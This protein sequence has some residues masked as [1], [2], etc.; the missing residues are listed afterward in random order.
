MAGPDAEQAIEEL[1]RTHGLGLVRFALLLV[2]DQPTAEDVV[3]EAFI[4]LYRG[5]HRVQDPGN[6]LAY[7]RSSVLN[8]C[9]SALRN[10]GRRL[11]LQ[12]RAALHDPPVWSAA[13]VVV[14]IGA[15]IAVPRLVTQPPGAAPAPTTSTS[16]GTTS[17]PFFVVNRID[18]LEVR[19]ATTGRIL[20]TVNP[21]DKQDGEALSP[22]GRTMYILNTT[23]DSHD[24]WLGL[25][26]YA[27]ST[28]TGERLRTLHIWK[29][30]D[31]V[32]PFLTT[33]GDKALVWDPPQGPIREVDL[34][35]GATRPFTQLPI[36]GNDS[37]VDIG[38]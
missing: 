32:S 18:S 10:R 5:W 35:T 22:D 28:A 2:G 31:S 15:T 3:Q 21:P 6:V 14:T 7:L 30:V 20:G 29:N 9:R 37:F 13:A 19:S 23:R 16:L 33:G 11:A 4:G 1:Y 38:W 17:P 34:A 24:G 26:L 8:G 27:Y 25:G 12:Q 36:N